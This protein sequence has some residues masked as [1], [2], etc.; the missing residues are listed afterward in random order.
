VIACLL[1]SALN[2]VAQESPDYLD[3]QVIP[4]SGLPCPA[5]ASYSLTR[6][7]PVGTPTVVGLAIFFQD[8]AQLNDVDQTLDADVYVVESWRDRRLADPA[9]GTE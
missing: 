9:R 7:D 2:L 3:R 6:P 8:V 5:L 4:H 1:L